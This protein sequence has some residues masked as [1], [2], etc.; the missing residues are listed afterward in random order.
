MLWLW[1]SI[2]FTSTSLCGR[3][4]GLKEPQKI[5]NNVGLQGIIPTSGVPGPTSRF[6][7]SPLPGYVSLT[8]P[9][10][11]FTDRLLQMMSRF[12]G[13]GVKFDQTYLY[14][15]FL[16]FKDYATNIGPKLDKFKYD[17]KLSPRQWGEGKFD[18][19]KIRT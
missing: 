9:S 12:E 2:E 19:S 6:L 4:L 7:I 5:L 17:T 14:R 1:T 15:E 10:Q 18:I 11:C 13:L 16:N 3:A 8:K